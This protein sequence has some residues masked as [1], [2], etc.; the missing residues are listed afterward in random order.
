MRSSIILLLLC[1]CDAADVSGTV[2]DAQVIPEPDALACEG[3]CKT[4]ALTATFMATGTL[5]VAYYGSNSDLT[6][7][8]EAYAGAAAGCPTMDSPAPDY[9]LILGRINSEHTS[10]ASFIDFKGDLLPSV[11][12]V[13]AT[14]VTLTP[15]TFSDMFVAYDVMLTF[16]AGTISGHFYATHCDSLDN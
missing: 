9:T 12:P 10:P 7:Y 4:T 14:A 6:L 8:V 5:D 15:V 3:A 1:A 16:D 2:H 11:Q 13:S